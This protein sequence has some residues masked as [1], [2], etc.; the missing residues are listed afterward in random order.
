MARSTDQLIAVHHET[1][2][3]K[4]RLRAGDPPRKQLAQEFVTVHGYKSLT[5]GYRRI[6]RA[7]REI[8]G[9]GKLEL[10]ADELIGRWEEIK[11]RAMESKR[12]GVVVECEK[13]LTLIRS[14]G[15]VDLR[16]PVTKINVLAISGGDGAASDVKRLAGRTS[17]EPLPR[18]EKRRLLA[19]TTDSTLRQFIRILEE[20]GDNGDG[21]I[22]DAEL[23]EASD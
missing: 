1:D 10:S 13:V 3:V 2:W 23:V 7:L 19:A 14:S 21:D 16:S 22:E 18:E 20:H 9:D 8:Y 15:A 12:F 11:S 17:T 5:T 4:K 6:N